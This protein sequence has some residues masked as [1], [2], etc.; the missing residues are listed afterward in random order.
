MA[1]GHLQLDTSQ[2]VALFSATTGHFRHTPYPSE[3]SA[4]TGTQVYSVPVNVG[5]HTGD[6]E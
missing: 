6:S 3:S 2:T 1:S 4:M 5:G